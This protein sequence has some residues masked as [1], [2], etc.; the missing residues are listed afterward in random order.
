M[1]LRDLD[2]Q[3]AGE[4]AH[5]AV[6]GQAGRLA[7]ATGHNLVE[8]GVSDVRWAVEHV[9]RYALDGTPPDDAPIDEYL[10]SLAPLYTR[11]SD[12]GTFTIPE[13]DSEADPTT[14]WGLALVAAVA[15]Q[16]LERGEPLTHGQLATL[17]SVSSHRLSQ[18]VAAG[19][20]PTSRA[21]GR[22]GRRRLYSARRCREWLRAR[23]L[24]GV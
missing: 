11:A 24:A 5:E 6:L 23:G 15:R 16:Q 22:D 14:P 2:P 9:A 12:G 8:A 18:L 1:R 20:A 7:M 4:Q 3:A 19:D 21:G 10:V 13:L 17:A